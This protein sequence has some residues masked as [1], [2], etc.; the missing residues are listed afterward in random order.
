MERPV[1]ARDCT[2]CFKPGDKTTFM[3]RVGPGTHSVRAAAV[4]WG[5]Q[6]A[7]F[8]A[9]VCG[10]DGRVLASERLPDCCRVPG[11]TDA[12]KCCTNSGARHRDQSEAGMRGRLFCS[13]CRLP[14]MP[15]DRQL[16]PKAEL[17]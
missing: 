11:L 16:R 12:L 7:F 15:I 1:V 10:A 14:L 17:G 4:K 5:R 2:L 13:D 3:S 9:Q 6:A 8:E